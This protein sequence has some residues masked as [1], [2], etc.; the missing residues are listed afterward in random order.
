MFEFE[1][2]NHEFDKR[3]INLETFQVFKI[4]EFGKKIQ[5]ISLN[6]QKSIIYFEKMFI[7][8]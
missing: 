8:F 1:E 4:H 7:E 2:K 6:L 5:K 3:F